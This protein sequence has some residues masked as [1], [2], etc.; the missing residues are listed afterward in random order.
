[1]QAS[2]HAGSKQR[3][4]LR[5][6]CSAAV[7]PVA[8][9]CAGERDLC[10]LLRLPPG[11]L[12][13]HHVFSVQ[14]TRQI[15]SRESG[16]PQ[17]M[18]LTMRE[19]GPACLAGGGGDFCF[20]LAGLS[21][22]AAF[23]CCCCWGG[24]SFSLPKAAA[25]SSELGL[26]AVSGTVATCTATS[27]ASHSICGASLS[28]PKATA[29]SSELGLCLCQAQWRPAQQPA[30]LHQ[31]ADLVRWSARASMVAAVAADLTSCQASACSS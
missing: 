2:R 29:T 21:P 5:S 3:H 19:H 31:F 15:R 26:C 8:N 7:A 11:R 20:L 4:Q 18:P 1:M 22:V 16:S 25:S 12:H 17:A 10:T 13:G 27:H 28:L 9:C 30:T 6:D 24:A 14:H 23:C